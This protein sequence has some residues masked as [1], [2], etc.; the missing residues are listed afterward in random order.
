MSVRERLLAET[1]E[2]WQREA[3]AR[4]EVDE[5]RGPPAPGDVF[6]LAESADSAVEWAVLDEAPDGRLLAVP[7][8]A[9]VLVGSAD[10]VA[11]RDG[12]PLTLRCA[13][14][15]RLEAVRLERGRRTARLTPAE[16]ARARALCSALEGG[17]AVGSV[18]EQEVDQDPEYRDWVEGVLEPARR[19]LLGAAE[20]SPATTSPATSDAAPPVEEPLRGPWG[21]R[22]ADRSGSWFLM[23]A[24]ILLAVGAGLVGGLLW[25][26]NRALERQLAAARLVGAAVANPVLALLDLTGSLRGDLEQILPAASTHLVLFFRLGDTDSSPA[27]RLEVVAEPSGATVWVLDGLRRTE[28]GE[29]MAGV[30][31]AVL[32]AGKYRLRLLGLE[33]GRERLLGEHGLRVERQGAGDG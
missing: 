13:F 20:T 19:T 27:Y 26:E 16:I 31:A 25:R 22:P 30:P 8:D 21:R 24:S 5:R 3:A 1:R 17:E 23:A 32:P 14:A 12:V 33:E 2:A 11:V 29:V 28:Y 15:V 9:D 6:V 7:A 4:A 10:A 18:P